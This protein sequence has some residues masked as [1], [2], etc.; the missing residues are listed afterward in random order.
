[1]KFRPVEIFKNILFIAVVGII[2]QQIITYGNGAMPFAIVSGHSME[3]TLNEGD[4]VFWYPVDV[5]SIKVGDIIVF[6]SYIR[7]GLVIHRVVEITHVNGEIAFITKGDA[8]NY[9]DQQRGEMPVTSRNFLGKIVTLDSAPLKIPLVGTLGLKFNEF[10]DFFAKFVWGRHT[11]REDAIIYFI[12]GAIIFA[13]SIFTSKPP[14]KHRLYVG[15]KDGIEV[16]K[17]FVIVFCIIFV[18]S[19]I[20]VALY[21]QQQSIA[22]GVNTSLE[23]VKK[24][25]IFD[26]MS[27]NSSKTSTYYIH[28]PCIF[29]VRTIVYVDG[30]VSKFLSYDKTYIV[31][32]GSQ[33]TVYIHAAVHYNAT[34]GTY[35]G[36]MHIY[37]SYLWTF[38]PDSF[39]SH[40]LNINPIFAIFVM[41]FLISFFITLFVIAFMF[42]VDILGFLYMAS[43]YEMRYGSTLGRRTYGILWDLGKKISA[44]KLLISKMFSWLTVTDGKTV[45]L[46]KTWPFIFGGAIFTI[47]C[48]SDGL[49]LPILYGGTII[50]AISFLF[51]TRKRAEIFFGQFIFAAIPLIFFAIKTSYLA[52]S[53]FVVISTFSI[54]YAISV[55]ILLILSVITIK[56]TMF[57]GKKMGFIIY[58]Y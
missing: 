20:P 3:G 36:N 45:D 48:I 52:D 40:L 25:I 37:T 47:V 27:W 57:V 28:D 55:F 42:L 33:H 44:M 16:K 18:I 1:L 2:I 35:V 8:N 24:D 32:P 51:I 29:P 53:Y 23:G 22:L 26:Y 54:L 38:F 58:D 11:G 41:N 30:N 49:I 31:D 13:I 46:R 15:R 5:N 39:V 10:R 7:N 14:L 6:R 56:I 17:I 34:N 21:S 4:V 9:T 50:S 19:F 12:I 43:G